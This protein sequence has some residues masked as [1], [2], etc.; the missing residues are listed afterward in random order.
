MVKFAFVALASVLATSANAG[1]SRAV[2]RKKTFKLGNRK[3]RRGDPATDALLNKARPYKRNAAAK[4]VSRARRLDDF[5]IDG[6]YNLKFSECVEIK[7]YDED[8]F[9]EDLVDYVQAGQIVQA[10]SYVLFH[11]CQG[12]DCYYDAEDDIY[13]VDLPTYLTN[14][15]TYH[16]NKRN[17]YCDAC[18]E[19]EDYCEEQAA[20]AGDDAAGDDAAGD[21]AAAN[22]DAAAAEDEGEEEEQQEDEEEEEQQEDEEEQEEEEEQQEEDNNEEE[23][24]QDEEQDNEGEEDNNE[25]EGEDNEDEERKLKENRKLAQ[26]VL[27][28]QYIDC[29]Q[30]NNYE[31]F[32]DYDE[33]DDGVVR[34]DELDEEVSEWVQDLAECKESGVQW[35][36]MDLYLGAMCSPHG[37]GVELAVFVDEDCTMY[38]NQMSFYNVFDPY[39][40]NEDG[41]NYLTYAEEFIK[42]A[43]TEVTSC[44]DQEYADPE[45]DNDEDD[46]EEEEYEVND[47]CQQVM[48]GDVADFNNCDVDENQDEE[49]IDDQYIWYTYDMQEADDIDEVCV[50]LNQM[51]GEYS[52]V[53]DEELS[54]T[55]YERNADGSI[56]SDEESEAATLSPGIIAV[57]V[58]VCLIVVGGAAF[59]LKPKKKPS[60]SNEPVYQGGTML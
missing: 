2:R 3:L 38:T 37:D 50:T 43:F 22:D 25:E 51:E 57:I 14:V 9:N 5:E 11:V 39:N 23:E 13:I 35:N 59:L 47:Y 56:H 1:N 32:V 28:K 55:W 30:C 49:D 17:D 19:F 53:Y 7:T 21:D 31:C 16:A 52:Y 36:D 48:E 27:S 54:G 6:S 45:E 18:E 20:A 33:M 4:N 58:A 15:A 34:R 8:L 12:D 29:D 42:Y 26:R 41:I 60:D 44:L 24:Q 40:D 46:D 10:S